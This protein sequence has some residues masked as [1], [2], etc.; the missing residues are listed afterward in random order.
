[1]SPSGRSASATEFS[2]A[3]VTPRHAEST[4]AS[5]GFEE[6]SMMSATRRKQPASA[7][8]DPPNLC[9]IH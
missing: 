4:T 3:S 1:M 9:T 5:R 7:T 2:N 6:A 8:L